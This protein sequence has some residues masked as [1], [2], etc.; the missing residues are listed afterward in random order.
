V[1]G[2]L[3]ALPL[4]VVAA[5][6]DVAVAV[7][8][9]T[10]VATVAAD[11]VAVATAVATA[12]ASALLVLVAALLLFV[13]ASG[14]FCLGAASMKGVRGKQHQMK[15]KYQLTRKFKMTDLWFIEIAPVIGGSWGGAPRHP[16]NKSPPQAPPSTPCWHMQAILC[17]ETS[18][19]LAT[20]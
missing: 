10:A 2:E 11:D 19:E 9:A 4:L 5:A 18:P 20:N 17:I 6:A 1:V 16:E 7:A 14:A 3:R 13:P 12:V 15:S 8:V